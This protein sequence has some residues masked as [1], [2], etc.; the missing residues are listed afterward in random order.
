MA[1]KDVR[2]KLLEDYEDVFAD[3]VNVLAFGGQR[4]L[5]PVRLREGPTVSRYKDGEADLR[6]QIRDVIKFDQNEAMLA[7]FGLENQTRE[8]PHMVFRVMGYDYGSYKYQMDR[9]QKILSPVITLVLHFGLTRWKE[10][11]DIWSAV[12]KDVPYRDYLKKNLPNFRIKVI[13]V[14]FLPKKVRELFTSDFRIVADY[15]SAVRKKRP[16][17]IRYDQRTI[18]HVAEILDFFATFG[19]DKRFQVCKP[20]LV[21]QAKKGEEIKMCIVMDYAEKQGIKQGMDLGIKQGLSQGIK[22]GRFL[23]LCDLVQSG[24]LTLEQAAGACQMTEKE[25]Q[26]QMESGN[27]L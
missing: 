9:E 18:R 5:D 15:F 7:V 23:Q 16:E 26:K 3:I 12:R 2:E 10:P 1:E 19:K 17:E 25:F 21:E 6:E 8:E 24:L 22:E 11:K 14:A 20:K 4:L 27:M 13:D